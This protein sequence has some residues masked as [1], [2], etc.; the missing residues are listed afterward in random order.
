MRLGRHY[1]R[2]C[3]QLGCAHGNGARSPADDNWRHSGRYR[4]GFADRDTFSDS[5][6]RSGHAARATRDRTR[7]VNRLTARNHDGTGDYDDYGTQH[8]VELDQ[9]RNDGHTDHD[10]DG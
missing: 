6:R 1:H 2:G 4:A 9:H 3:Q 8:D 10:H 7:D 5:A